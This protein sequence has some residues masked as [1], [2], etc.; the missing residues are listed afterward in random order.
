MIPIAN[1]L[2]RKAFDGGNH[3]IV[4]HQQTVIVAFEKC[5]DDDAARDRTGR[6]VR[7]CNLVFGFKFDAHAATGLGIPR[8]YDDWEP[9]A[10]G[11]VDRSRLRT[12]CNLPWGRQPQLLQH[13]RGDNLVPGHPVIDMAE[14]I[15]GGSDN[16][17]LS[18]ALAEHRDLP[19]DTRPRDAAPVCGF[20][21]IGGIQVNRSP[22]IEPVNR[23]T[24]GGKIEARG[25]AAGPTEVGGDEVVNQPQSQPPGPPSNV[26]IAVFENDFM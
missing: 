25:G 6:R 8:L 20:Q 13:M 1:H 24:L 21:Q 18:I 5:F 22:P 3:Y 17:T 11:R 19:V 26:D 23:A 4:D 7:L 9:D 2:S 14:Q 15:S 12:D 16:M 10:F